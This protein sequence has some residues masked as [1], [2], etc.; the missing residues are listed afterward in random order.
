MMA[1]SIALDYLMD[2]N[3][4]DLRIRP[5]GARVSL[6]YVRLRAGSLPYVQY[7]GWPN[8]YRRSLSHR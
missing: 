8:I 3:W 1:L 7:D 6:A 2:C 5:F 4:R